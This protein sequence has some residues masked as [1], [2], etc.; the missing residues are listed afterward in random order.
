MF[1]KTLAWLM[2]LCLLLCCAPALADGYT[3]G[4]YEAEAK[5]NNGPVKVSVT[6]SADAITDVQVV[7]HGETAA[8]G[9]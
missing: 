7:E 4:T 8:T 2:A 6:F 9:K 1:R 3:A 5:G